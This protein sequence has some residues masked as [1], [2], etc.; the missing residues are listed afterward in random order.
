MP[1]S[2]RHPTDLRFAASDMGLDMRIGTKPEEL[3]NPAMKA[4]FKKME[5][6]T[7]HPEFAARLAQFIKHPPVVEN[8]GFCSRLSAAAGFASPDPPDV[9]GCRSRNIDCTSFDGYNFLKHTQY[10]RSRVYR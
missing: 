4:L 3:V 1:S 6:D 5:T 9:D 2:R 8:S 10:F 7:S